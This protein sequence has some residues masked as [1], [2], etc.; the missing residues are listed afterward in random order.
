MP[1]TVATAA[2][3]AAAAHRAPPSKEDELQAA[4]VELVR[5][6]DPLL[7]LLQLLLNDADVR[8]DARSSIFPAS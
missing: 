5:G 8:S 1:A 3:V 7:P 2:T 6:P 4:C